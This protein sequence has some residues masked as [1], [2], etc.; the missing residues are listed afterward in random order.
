MHV[1]LVRLRANWMR[2]L[3][4]IF[5]V[6][7]AIAAVTAVFA[8]VLPV[9][10]MPTPDPSLFQV[11]FGT[12]S[13]TSMSWRSAFTVED[14]EVLLQEA[15]TVEAV[16]VYEMQP[17]QLIRVGEERYLVQSAA[18]VS[19]SYA[20]I[21]QF[22]LVGGGF[23]TAE[24][25]GE[26]GPRAVVISQELAQLLFGEDRPV[27]QRINLRPEMERAAMSAFGTMPPERVAAMQADPG[28]DV[29]VVGVFRPV[30]DSTGLVRGLS[31]HMFLPAASRRP[32]PRLT[33]AGGRAQM[34]RFSSALF[35]N[36]SELLIKVRDGMVREAEEEVRAIL[37]E[38]VAA[39]GLAGG[40]ME[41]REPDIM[42]RSVEESE[43]A[44]RT[45][46]LRGSLITG[47]MGLVALIVA[48]FA[49]FTT[50]SAN[51]TQRTRD[52]GLARAIGATR[53][54]VIVEVVL[55][56]IL[57]AGIGGVIGVLAAYP[58]GRHILA[59]IRF[60]V[61]QDTG[62]GNQLLAGLAGVILAMAIGAVAALYPGWSVARLMPAEAWREGRV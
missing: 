47:A 3:L 15:S 13:A 38:R 1:F 10:R 42:F 56:A 45:A 9:L 53:R 61:A 49:V 36:Y 51:L 48:G 29:E 30:G 55:E 32:T 34:A 37:R 59:P 2:N 54:H 16:S 40:L 60:S 57:L 25:A 24:D 33:S 62:L 17:M 44:I 20:D 28:T 18:Q 26:S 23:F 12:R 52:I 27:G 43:Q 14:A 22:E 31:P 50:T 7:I 5:Q 19:P 6:A 41:G 58:L 21:G 8:D 46:R 11:H 4:A 39:R 35:A